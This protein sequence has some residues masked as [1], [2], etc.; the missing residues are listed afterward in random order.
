MLAASNS[1]HKYKPYIIF[2]G[3]RTKDLPKVQ[4]CHIRCSA[5]GWMSED[6]AVDWVRT[7]FTRFP[8]QKNLLVWDTYPTHK[9]EEV[10][11][12]AY[13]CNTLQKF[14]PGGCTGLLQ[15]PDVSWNKPFKGMYVNSDFL[16][17]KC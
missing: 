9:M 3:K 17:L 4:G 2:K 11:T 12:E 6:L 16:W 14:I 7:T 15:P 10:A 1:G 8:S 5:K 13:Q